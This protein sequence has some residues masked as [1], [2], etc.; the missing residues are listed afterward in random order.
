MIQGLPPGEFCAYGYLGPKQEARQTMVTVQCLG[1]G[2][3]SVASVFIFSYPTW[4]VHPCRP[5]L[6]SQIRAMI[7]KLGC[8]D[9]QH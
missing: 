4:I 2:V 9:R 1:S 6:L 8:L 5:G 3:S 7:C